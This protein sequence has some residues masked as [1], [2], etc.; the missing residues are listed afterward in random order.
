MLPFLTF[1]VP[2]RT[3]NPSLCNRQPKALC[4]RKQAV[5]TPKQFTNRCLTL[6]KAASD[7]VPAGQDNEQA[8]ASERNEIGDCATA[9]VS[10]KTKSA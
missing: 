10:L 7:N 6:I 9:V 8:D 4:R 5:V 1:C 3:E 2:L